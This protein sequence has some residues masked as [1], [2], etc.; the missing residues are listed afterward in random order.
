[1]N[2]SETDSR[3]MSASEILAAHGRGELK[4]AFVWKDGMTDW[5]PLLEVPELASLVRSKGKRSDSPPARGASGS[6]AYADTAPDAAKPAARVA[7][8]RGGTQ[9]LFGAVDKAGSE[10]EAQHAHAADANPK[11][12]GARNENSVLFSLDALKAGLTGASNA[13]IAK[14]STKP[15]TA[16]M[17][18]APAPPSPGARNRDRQLDDVMN[19][20]GGGLMFS[21]GG[22]QATLLTAP[23][24]VEPP[25]PKPKPVEPAPAPA[26]PPTSAPPVETSAEAAAAAAQAAVAAALTSAPPPLPQAQAQTTKLILM[27]GGLL[28]V[29]TIVGISVA[30]VLGR[31]S[32]GGDQVARAESQGV[33]MASTPAAP[34]QRTEPAALAAAPAPGSA[35]PM[36]AAV[37]PAPLQ[38]A[39]ALAGAAAPAGARKVGDKPDKAT[40]KA[41]KAEPP[42][43]SDN[44]GRSLMDAIRPPGVPEKPEKAEAPKDEPKKVEAAPKAPSGGFDKGAAVAALNSASGGAVAC[45]RPDG[46]TGTG[47]VTVTFAPS[48]RATNAVVSG[49]S[50][51]GTSVGGCV[52]SVFRRARV[53]A[54]TGDPVTVSKS[55]TISP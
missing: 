5:R 32:A 50:F 1:V 41:E 24:P 19:I 11:L 2:L 53:P 17:P 42:P 36:A 8:A 43:A 37:A 18:K 10:E 27:M 51:P 44:P 23:A 35:V 46:P 4:D 34:V 16:F 55:F 29:L 26:A 52:A 48:G 9:D 6:A 28:G 30:F 7:S 20:G 54:F 14:P 49:G 13:P 38:P 40:A 15:L 31:K 45:K 39:N 21:L 12:T 25:K 33:P 22:D 47:R 3:T